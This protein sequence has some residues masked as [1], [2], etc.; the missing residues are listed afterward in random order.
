[1]KGGK[2]AFIIGG[3]RSG[4]GKTTMTMGILGALAAAGHD[5]QPWKAGPD[6]IDPGFLGAAAGKICRNLDTMILDE[7]VIGELFESRPGDVAVVEGVMGL[8]DG[9]GPLDER[10]SAAHLSKIL[11]LPV[12]LVL[13][14]TAVAR[15]A[16]ATALGFIEFDREVNIAGFLINK[17]GSE[18]H[19]GIIKTAIEE[20][21]GKPVLGYLMKDS[22]FILPER[23]LGLDQD[24]ES[25]DHGRIRDSIIEAVGRTVELEKLLSLADRKLP[26]QRPRTGIFG[27]ET[28]REPFVTIAV[29]RDGAF[30]FYYEDNLDILRHRGARIRFFSPLKDRSVGEGIDAVYL[31]GGYP[32]LYAG[33]L[34]ANGDLLAQLRD[35]AGK[36]L[37]VYGECGGFMY[38]TEEIIDG[39]GRSFPMAGLLPGKA[40][41]GEKLKAL[42]YC[43]TETNCD[44]ILGQRGTRGRGHVFHWSALEEGNTGEPLVFTVR[45]GTRV[46]EEG[47]Q[48][49][50]VLGSW[51][52]HHF[53][54]NPAM[55]GSFIEAAEK[56][57]R[58]RDGR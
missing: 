53:A 24:I 55:A 16:A 23:H 52:H 45:K 5:V 18:H 58:L 54:A 40:R 31:G 44:T 25:A 29:A 47:F 4:C 32:E 48:R 9:A 49:H 10:G 17:V 37:P 7:P 46:L 56:Y 27:E 19:Y 41:L 39:E 21:T 26:E 20:R 34:S 43:E 38:L 30:R 12:F 13:D 50:N 35:L 2:K 1:M 51:V 8:Y 36:G 42:G 11:K 33:E 3:T 22:R 15:S 6:Y 28:R 14:G 57:G